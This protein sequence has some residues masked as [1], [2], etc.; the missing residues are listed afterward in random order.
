MEYSPVGLRY[1]YS[2]VARVVSITQSAL[3]GPDKA[4]PRGSGAMDAGARAMLIEWDVTVNIRSLLGTAAN[5]NARTV[6][7]LQ[8]LHLCTA[9]VFTNSIVDA[10]TAWAIWAPAT[11]WGRGEFHP[12]PC[13]LANRRSQRDERG[14]V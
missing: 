10:D 7:M 12:S 5:G 2:V 13:Y 9:N 14:S 11:S 8:H 4:R 3:K 1:P 6:A